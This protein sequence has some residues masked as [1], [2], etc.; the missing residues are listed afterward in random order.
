MNN[1]SVQKLAEAMADRLLAKGLR[2]AE[3][4]AAAFQLAFARPPTPAELKAS[5]DFFENFAAA[6]KGKTMSKERLGKAGL[7]AFCQALLGSAE[8]R[9]VN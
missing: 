1:A 9:Y 4:G 6:E 2:G 8:F 3:L 7:V 5:Q